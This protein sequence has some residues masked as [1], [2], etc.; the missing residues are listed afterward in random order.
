MSK[1][2]QHPARRHM[3]ARLAL[4]AKAQRERERD[5]E[6]GDQGRRRCHECKSG[7]V[8][9]GFGLSAVTHIQKNANYRPITLLNADIKLLMLI[10]SARLQR[11][12]DY[13]IDIV[14]SLQGC[15]DA[16]AAM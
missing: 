8:S 1:P 13:L 15:S 14:F 16:Q 7:A 5:R 6:E 10:M 2:P 12:L 9:R 11:P 4:V 3:A